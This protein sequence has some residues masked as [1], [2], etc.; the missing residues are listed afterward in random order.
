ELV[1]KKIVVF[2]AWFAAAAWAQTPE[3]NGFYIFNFSIHNAQGEPLITCGGDVH[4]DFA[5]GIAPSKVVVCTGFDGVPFE[6]ELERPEDCPLDWRG[7][8]VLPAKGKPEIRWEC[9]GDTPFIADNVSFA[10]GDKVKGEG[11]MCRREEDGL[12]CVND[13]GF[14][15][16]V[17]SKRYT[18]IDG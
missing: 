11:W 3:S 1:M 15:F 18:L 2:A 16:A 8:F 12:S 10:V 6:P 7:F 13:E 4:A 5:A 14:G 17:N 9:A